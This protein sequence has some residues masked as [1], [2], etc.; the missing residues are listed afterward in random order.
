MFCGAIMPV[1]E[2]GSGVEG[3]MNGE[4]WLGPLELQ[5]SRL[6]GFFS[7]VCSGSG[8]HALFLGDAVID[9]D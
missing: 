6:G 8:P 3:G 7:G 9:S 1:R 2:R 5:L 4:A